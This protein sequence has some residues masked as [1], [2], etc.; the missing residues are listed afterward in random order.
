M[1]N[2]LETQQLVQKQELKFIILIIIIHKI[3]TNN[4]NY[5]TLLVIKIPH[6]I[7]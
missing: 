1:N 3:I 7:H 6:L 4:L 5:L 2:K